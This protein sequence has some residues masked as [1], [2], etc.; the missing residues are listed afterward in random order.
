MS[1]LLSWCFGQAKISE[2]SQLPSGVKQT[3]GNTICNNISAICTL[4]GLLVPHLISI[5]GVDWLSLSFYENAIISELVLHYVM[6]HNFLG[7][8][9]YTYDELVQNDEKKVIVC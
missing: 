9:A 1:F 4:E 5:E 8:N 7:I 3:L 6:V 2:P